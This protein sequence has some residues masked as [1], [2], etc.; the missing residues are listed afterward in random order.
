MTK[1]PTYEI[2]DPPRRLGDKVSLA[3][4]IDPNTWFENSDR[5]VAALT[6]DLNARL[7]EQVAALDHAFEKARADPGNQSA[8]IKHYR[9]V[10]A[11][12]IEMGEPLGYPLVS[13]ICRS[14][15]NTVAGADWTAVEMAA[16]GSHIDAVKVVMRD[17][18]RSDGGVVG[19]ELVK[20]L[21]ELVDS[22]N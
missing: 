11:D 18:V 12:L 8:P 15:R 13:A 3:P 22:K 19:R 21:Q 9:K 16:C 20:A 10:L 5:E 7:H 17:E 4:H 2:I 6:K 1:A 14:L